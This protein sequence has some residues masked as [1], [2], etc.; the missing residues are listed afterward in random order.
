M[1]SLFYSITLFYKVEMCILS[2]STNNKL[3]TSYWKLL[4]FIFNMARH[5]KSLREA[6]LP[7]LIMNWISGMGII[8]FPV[9]KPR[10]FIS[11]IYV[12]FFIFGCLYLSMKYTDCQ[13]GPSSS[14]GSYVL[15]ALNI[16]NKLIV[17][18]SI[19][20]CWYYQKVGS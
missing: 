17:L 10:K 7:I 18:I 20:Y 9:G 3:H 16:Y 4:R 19:F 6:L 8:E 1:I 11:I 15:Q 2:Q 5:P 13:M 14:P 12:A